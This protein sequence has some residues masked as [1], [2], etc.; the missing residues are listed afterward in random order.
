M[1]YLLRRAAHWEWN[2]HKR[3]KYIAVNKLN[4]VGDLKSALTSDMEMQSLE[5]V[6]LV[7]SPALVQCFLTMLPFL[8]FGM[9]MYLDVELSAP[10]ALCLP[11]WLHGCH[12]P[13]HTDNGLNLRTL[14]N[15]LKRQ[16]TLGSI[17]TY[18][19]QNPSFTKFPR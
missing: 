11:A 14:F 10:P 4:G 2:H 19:N 5:F 17:Q 8:L 13:L 18:R 9:V 3:K 12:A 6:Q 15:V 16:R 7:F 1:G